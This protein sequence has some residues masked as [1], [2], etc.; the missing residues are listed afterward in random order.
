MTRNLLGGLAFQLRSNIQSEYEALRAFVDQGIF[1]NPKFSALAVTVDDG[2]T[3][4]IGLDNL[5]PTN[6]K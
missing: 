6:P 3:P 4:A 5:P 2:K 1:D